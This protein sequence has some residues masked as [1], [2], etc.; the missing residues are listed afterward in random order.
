MELN[1][2]IEEGLY[3]DEELNLSFKKDYFV[4]RFDNLIDYDNLINHKNTTDG[5]KQVFDNW[6]QRG[7][8][9]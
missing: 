5:W 1:L 6:K 3:I 8:L 9:N 7:I 4:E 2:K